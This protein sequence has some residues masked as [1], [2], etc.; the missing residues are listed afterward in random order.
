M[1]GHTALF[2]LNNLLNCKSLGEWTDKNLSHIHTTLKTM[3]P[4]QAQDILYIKFILIYNLN[5]SAWKITLCSICNNPLDVSLTAGLFFST[6]NQTA[7]DKG[8]RWA[9]E[10]LAKKVYGRPATDWQN[11]PQSIKQ[12]YSRYETKLRRLDS[13][14]S[15]ESPW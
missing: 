13:A 15:K 2:R 6:G 4:S 8:Y 7:Q 1:L 10:S 12:I 5:E 11:P 14:A 3:N 9:Y